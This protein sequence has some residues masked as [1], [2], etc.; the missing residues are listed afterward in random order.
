MS[1]GVEHY[2]GTAWGGAA[3]AP[4]AGFY[5]LRAFSVTSQSLVVV[6]SA[7]P[8]ESSPIGVGDA[9]NRDTWVVQDQDTGAVFTI[10]EAAIYPAISNAI[11]IW[12]LEE[13][14]GHLDTYRV[15]TTTLQ[16]DFQLGLISDPNY[17]EFYG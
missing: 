8:T 14:T 6:L 1:W 15:T 7:K 12:T 4:D 17:A 13:F 3:A 11:Q 2:G 16:R 5:V 9:L 10:L